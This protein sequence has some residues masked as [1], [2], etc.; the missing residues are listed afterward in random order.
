MNLND[1]LGE[2]GSRTGLGRVELNDQG[3]CRLVFDGHWALDIE[4]VADG[5]AALLHTVV[6][7]LPVDDREA[8]Y[9]R[10]LEFNLAGMAKGS[11]AF[12]VDPQTDEVIACMRLWLDGTDY[13]VFTQAVEYLLNQ[14][15][16]WN[17]R[18]NPSDDFADEAPE[19][20]AHDEVEHAEAFRQVVWQRV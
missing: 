17:N 2:F 6:D 5:H 16:S 20:T 11:M 10:L 18:L 15:E 12:A 7:A 3:A 9:R 19:G 1:I 8:Y 14:A 4:S 13:P